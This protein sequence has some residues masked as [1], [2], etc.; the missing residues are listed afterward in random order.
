M[1]FVLFE[2][3]NKKKLKISCENKEEFSPTEIIIPSQTINDK[4]DDT[5]LLKIENDYKL[6]TQFGCAI[7]DES[8]KTSFPINESTVSTINP[9]NSG[10]PDST[11]IPI[12]DNN[13]LSEYKRYFKKGSSG[14]TDGAIAGI[15]ICVAV[16]AIAAT[17]ILLSKRGF[18]SKTVPPG[19]NYS[20]NP[21]ASINKFTLNNNNQ[22]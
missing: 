9:D 14:V 8:L 10:K 1:D 7:S 16:V 17:I 13:T 19:I 5:P 18:F 21:N 12:T 3:E 20:I 2:V 11:S 4:D 6:P 15:I 22:I